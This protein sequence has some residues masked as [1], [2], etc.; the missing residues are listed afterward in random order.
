[1]GHDATATFASCYIE[2][3]IEGGG[4]GLRMV[5]PETRAAYLQTYFRFLQKAFFHDV[6]PLVGF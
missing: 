1:M 4:V 3:E 6:N 5:L 2:E